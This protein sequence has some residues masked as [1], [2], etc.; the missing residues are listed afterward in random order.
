M[1]KPLQIDYF[2]LKKI[3]NLQSKKT[4]ASR[5]LSSRQN[6]D[7]CSSTWRTD[8]IRSQFCFLA[9]TKIHRVLS[10]F[11]SLPLERWKDSDVAMSMSRIQFIHFTSK[12]IIRQPPP[13]SSA[14]F[15]FSC[16]CLI[17]ARALTKWHNRDKS[18]C[19]VI[20][21][22]LNISSMHWTTHNRHPTSATSR[23]EMYS[24]RWKKT[25]LSFLHSA[26]GY[27]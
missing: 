14:I 4:M 5:D 25:F 26:D 7:L 15:H 23:P 13:V 11:Q 3:K 2:L 16:K 24:G 6:A 18:R 9:H 27:D 8:T 21:G 1:R 17:D 10:F 20:N 12:N 22:S 19:E